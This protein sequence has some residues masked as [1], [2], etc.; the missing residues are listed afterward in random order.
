[1]NKYVFRAYDPQA[2]LLFEE[3][4][5]RLAVSVGKKVLIEHVGSTAVPGLGGKGIIDLCIATVKGRM[6]KLS[7]QAQNAG[8]VFIAHASFEDRLFLQIDLSLKT[9]G[10]QRYHLHIVN[11]TSQQYSNLIIFRDFLRSHPQ[12][13]KR[14]V[15]IKQAA[16][17]KSNENKDVY[18]AIKQP[19]IEDILKKAILEIGNCS[20]GV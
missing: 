20:P 14:Y 16:A 12:I 5:I 18:M 10:L 4:K 17:R 13:A 11:K 6:E 9:G 3:E 19:M 15:A 1:M 2:P 8:Y 7:N